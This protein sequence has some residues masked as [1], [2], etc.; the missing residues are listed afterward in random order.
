MKE[1]KEAS[2]RTIDPEIARIWAMIAKSELTPDDSSAKVGP[3][4]NLNIEDYIKFHIPAYTFAKALRAIPDNQ[5]ICLM[6]FLKTLQNIGGSSGWLFGKLHN[7]L[8]NIFPFQKEF[9]Q[10]TCSDSDT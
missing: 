6:S 10:V 4:F 7:A 9:T 5:Q 3:K 2:E 8:S 1:A